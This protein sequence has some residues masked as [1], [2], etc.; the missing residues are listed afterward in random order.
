MID[1]KEGESILFPKRNSIH[2]VLLIDKPSGLSSNNVLQKVKKMFYINKAGHTGALDPLAT[3]MLP[4]CF[5]EATK[6]AQYSIDSDKY[7]RVIAKLGEKTTTSD[8]DGRII[9]TRSITFTDLEFRTALN[10]FKGKIKQIP[11]LYS[12]IKYKGIPLYKYARKGITTIPRISR[13]VIIYQLTCI[14][15]SKK[16]FELEIKC[17][18]GTYI[19]TIIDDLGEILGCGAHVIL[20]RRLQVGSYPICKMITLHKLFSLISI[21]NSVL[22]KNIYNF[23]MPID[24]PISSFPEVTISTIAAFYFRKGQKI[25]TTYNYVNKLVRVIENKKFIGLGE[26]DNQGFI[27]PRRLLSDF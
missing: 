3:G 2:G 13:T 27:Q 22:E 17:S 15:R 19:R 23:L 18:K 8:S 9:K 16:F 26:I 25:K 10:Q 6:F 24:S 4:I 14:N 12:A 20:L 7:Y 5:G 1:N 21:N 11:S